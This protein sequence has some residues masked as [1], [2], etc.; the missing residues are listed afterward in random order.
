[1]TLSALQTRCRGRSVWR[2]DATYAV[3]CRCSCS[4]SCASR[5]LPSTR[6]QTNAPWDRHLVKLQKSKFKSRGLLSCVHSSKVFI[7]CELLHCTWVITI[8]STMHANTQR[9]SY[10]LWG[11]TAK[12]AQHGNCCT[13]NCWLPRWW[14]VPTQPDSEHRNAA[15]LP[16]Q[17]LFD[18]CRRPSLSLRTL[19]GQTCRVE[20][21]IKLSLTQIFISLL[22]A[23]RALCNIQTSLKQSRY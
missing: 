18:F 1:M 17:Q 5:G 15:R 4:V 3:P 11:A 21:C 23:I 2:A 13:S 14:T 22:K 8:C 7:M 20:T 19:L 6:V 9:R 12:E 10:R 16:A